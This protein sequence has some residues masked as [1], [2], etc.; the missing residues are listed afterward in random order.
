MNFTAPWFAKSHEH[1]WGNWLAPML[2]SRGPVRI[3]EIGCYEGAATT[4]LLTHVV[5]HHEE[6]RIVCVDPWA[7]Q[8]NG[9]DYEAAHD[10]FLANVAETG[11]AER[12]TVRRAPSVDVLGDMR[13]G[14]FD[15]IYV[16]GGHSEGCVAYDTEQALR[17]VKRDGIV[18]WDDVFFV[19]DATP[20]ILT[21]LERGLRASGVRGRPIVRVDAAAVLFMGALP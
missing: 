1:S 8:G 10:R 9:Y 11:L 17:L 6:S 13:G 16:D 3:L 14:V 19:C 12:V 4:W 20:Q 2:V 15:F 5:R 18:A 21:G 7:A